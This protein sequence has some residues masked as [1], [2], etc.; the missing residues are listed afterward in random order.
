MRRA[1]TILL[2]T[3]VALSAGG[4]AAQDVTA[5][6]R[7][8][9][10]PWKLQ[11]EPDAVAKPALLA[12]GPVSLHAAGG[13]SGAGLSLQTGQ[14][15]F[16]RAAVGANVDSEAVSV[17]G[18]YRFSD[19]DALS[20]HVTRQLGQERLGLAVRYDRAAAYLR[21]SYEGKLGSTGQAEMLKFSAGVRF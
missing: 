18:G 11:M 15:W 12:L 21:V 4:V 7:L 8:A 6:Y 3:G 2:S 5:N 13:G 16:A 14:Q 1:T 20:M 9:P 10:S 17:G 19:G